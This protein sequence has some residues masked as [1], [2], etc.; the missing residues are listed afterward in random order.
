MAASSMLFAHA[1]EQWG[2]GNR[3]SFDQAEVEVLRRIWSVIRT[4]DSAD[5]EVNEL[6]SEDR[7]DIMAMF[8]SSERPD[9]AKLLNS[10]MA[11]T[12]SEGDSGS[13]TSS[14]ESN[15]EPKDFLVS[16]LAPERS[17]LDPSMSEHVKIGDDGDTNEASS[18]P[19]V[20]VVP[21]EGPNDAISDGSKIVDLGRTDVG[22]K[23]TAADEALLADQVA[24]EKAPFL[25][26][27][28][29]WLVEEADASVVEE[30]RLAE[31]AV[32]TEWVEAER[33][34]E[35]ARVV[36]ETKGQR[37]AEKTEGE[38][39]AEEWT[40]LEQ[41]TDPNN[42]NDNDNGLQAQKPQDPTP[43]LQAKITSGSSRTTAWTETRTEAQP[44]K[45]VKTKDSKKTKQSSQN[46]LS[47]PSDMGAPAA[48]TNRARW[49][50]VGVS[51]VVIVT[52]AALAAFGYLMLLA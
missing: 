36:A 38:F 11:W 1:I 20:R 26:E 21:A 13:R 5:R 10:A 29:R 16:D 41:A 46:K 27:A 39:T 43:S 51:L 7:E 49:S 40:E 33:V 28:Q 35:E 31:Q 15:N 34:T 8:R 44:R 9:V 52:L 37:L 47:R 14:T 2:R 17:S 48:A 42:D 23:R 19:F 25:G 18:G 22:D 6:T 4:S 12:R 50:V 24:A 3:T 45:N 30:K 32:D